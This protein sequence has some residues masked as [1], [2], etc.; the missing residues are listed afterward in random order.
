[1]ASPLQPPG[2]HF[3]RPRTLNLSL[4]PPVSTSLKRAFSLSLSL[5]Q[6]HVLI[7]SHAMIVSHLFQLAKPPLLLNVQWTRRALPFS[8]SLACS[9]ALYLSQQAMSIIPPQSALPCSGKT[10]TPLKSPVQIQ[11][12]KRALSLSFSLS[13]SLILSLSQQPLSIFP[14]QSALPCF[15]QCRFRAPKELSLSRSLS[16]PTPYV[17]IPRTDSRHPSSA[18]F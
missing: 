2:S 17:H 4:L 8:L 15:R 10:I 18:L 1:M 6:Q 13:L 16:L 9:L 5:S 14:R 3:V 7:C 12:S 11:S